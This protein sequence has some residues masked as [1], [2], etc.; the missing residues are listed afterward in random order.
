MNPISAE[1]VHTVA[2]R[3]DVARHPFGT[4]WSRFGESKAKYAIGA[5]NCK[6]L[7][8]S[9]ALDLDAAVPDYY[10]PWA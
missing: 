10:S 8:C 5:L 7:Y 9:P 2:I 6:F 1:E 3:P 4:S